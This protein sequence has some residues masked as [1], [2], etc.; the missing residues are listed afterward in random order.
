[1]ILKSVKRRY[2]LVNFVSFRNLMVTRSSE[3]VVP[4]AKI[5][6]K[7]TGMLAITSMKNQLLIYAMASYF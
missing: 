4:L 5:M 6:M 1:M 3:I 7:E 2:S